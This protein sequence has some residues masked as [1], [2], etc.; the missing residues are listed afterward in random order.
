MTSVRRTLTC[1]ASPATPNHEKTPPIRLTADVRAALDI[2]ITL[3]ATTHERAD[4]TNVRFP[5]VD[6]DSALLTGAER[7]AI[8]QPLLRMLVLTSAAPT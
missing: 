6:L 3:A 5:A 2:A 4:L 7:S 1:A 8:L